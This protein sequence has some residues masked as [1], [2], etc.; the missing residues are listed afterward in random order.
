[1]DWFR[2]YHGLCTDPKLHR[3]ARTAGCSRGLV[4]AAWCAILE[5]A[6]AAVPRGNAAALDHVALAFLVDIK[7]HVASKILDAIRIFG[8]LDTDGNV[9]AWERRQRSSDDVAVRKRIQRDRDREAKALEN[10]KTDAP[11]RVTVTP[12][13][14]QNR[15]DKKD[16]GESPLNPPKPKVQRGTRIPADWKASEADR[17]YARGKGLTERQIDRAE[18]NFLN[19][20]TAKS[21]RDALK[22]DWPATW[23]NRIM[24]IAEHIGV[25][26][27]ATQRQSTRRRGDPMEALRTNLALLD[28]DDDRHGSSRLETLSRMPV[29]NA[30]EL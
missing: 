10:H 12:R 11:G 5:T 23:R 26:S 8:L 13:T 7:P 6:S 22:C 18:E 17:D 21:G 28:E 16:K 25:Q 9:V 1:M 19:Y 2:H 3:V 4:V 27:P 20:W 14:E 30:L 15:T 29:A 24:Q